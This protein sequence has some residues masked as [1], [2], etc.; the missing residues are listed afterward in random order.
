MDSLE[1]LDRKEQLRAELNSMLDNAEKEQRKLTEDETTRFEALNTEI[2]NLD[3]QI[4]DI[5]KETK[6]VRKMGKFSLLKAINDI[7]NN[8]Q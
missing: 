1:I 5:K 4:I 6:E 3:K 2:R 8:R 7:A